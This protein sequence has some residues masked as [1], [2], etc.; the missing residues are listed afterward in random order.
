MSVGEKY[1]VTQWY[2]IKTDKN[3]KHIYFKPLGMKRYGTKKVSCFMMTYNTKTYIVIRRSKIITYHQL[4]H[5]C[6]VK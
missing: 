2:L 5:L 3:L 1:I 6:G 4:T